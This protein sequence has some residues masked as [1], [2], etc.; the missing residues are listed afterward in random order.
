M[1]APN[2]TTFEACFSKSVLLVPVVN[3]GITGMEKEK[4]I[5]KKVKIIA[6]TEA[7]FRALSHS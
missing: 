4:K 7:T 5:G 2:T 1:E 3:S 6:S